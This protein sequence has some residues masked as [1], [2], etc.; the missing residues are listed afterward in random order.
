MIGKE[1]IKALVLE[2]IQG[3][4]LFLVDIKVSTSNKIEVFIDGDEGL[5]IKDCVELSRFIEKNLDRDKEDFSLV[6]SS[7]GATTPLKMARQY[8]KHMG[9]DLEIALSD[10][11]ELTGK[12]VEININGKE[13]ITIETTRREPKIIGKGKMTVTEKHILNLNSIKESKIKLKF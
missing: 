11:T 5:A 13:E 3:T 4:S 10:G 8:V 9:R 12:L 2:K 7:P 6:V 1:Q